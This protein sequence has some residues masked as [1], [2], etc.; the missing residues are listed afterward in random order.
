MRRHR[1]FTGLLVLVAAL[2]TLAISVSCS[3]SKKDDTGGGGTGNADVDAIAKERGL[4]PEDVKHA[5]MQ[6][7]PPGKFDDYV[8]FA[9]GGHSGQVY[10][11]GM[12]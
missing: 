7:V 1:R 5:A 9:S 2:L 4:T 10:V 11:I 3:S 8:M 6:Y 12:P